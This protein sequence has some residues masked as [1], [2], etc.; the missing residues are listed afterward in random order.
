MKVEKRKMSRHEKK[1]M[2][3]TVITF[4]KE[5]NQAFKR[6]LRLYSERMDKIEREHAERVKENARVE[7]EKKCYENV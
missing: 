3:K 7:K 2:E 6:L 5:D 1:E 4:I